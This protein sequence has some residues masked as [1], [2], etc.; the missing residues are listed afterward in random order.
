MVA[1]DLH[2][3]LSFADEPSGRITL[4][5]DDPSLPTD[6]QNLVVRAA[7]RLKAEAGTSRGA[8]IDLHKAIPAPAGLAGSPRR[9]A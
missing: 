8:S 2:D 6:R 3:R 5:C 1:V 9:A 4:R 7:E